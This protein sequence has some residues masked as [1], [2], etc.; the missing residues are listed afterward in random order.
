MLAVG[1][2]GQL[3][4][5]NGAGAPTWV[6][7]A[8]PASGLTLIT[9]LTASNSTSL[10]FT[11]TSITSTYDTYLFVITSLKAVVGNSNLFLRNGSPVPP[12]NY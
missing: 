3:L 1:T 9:T 4:Q 5:T 11:N 7:P 12:Q 8:T 6:T 2:A 10:T